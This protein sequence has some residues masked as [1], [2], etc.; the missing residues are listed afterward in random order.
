ME[1]G[2]RSTRWERARALG[3]VKFAQQ[4]GEWVTGWFGSHRELLEDKTHQIESALQADVAGTN[5]MA[6]FNDI[7]DAVEIVGWYQHQ[8]EVKLVRALSGLEDLDTEED[9]DTREFARHDSDGSAKVALIGIDRSLAAWARLREHFADERD[10]ILDTLVLLD[11][12]RR[13][14]EALLP[15]A[16]SF[17]RPGFDDVPKKP[18]KSLRDQKRRR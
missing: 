8:I 13:G 7:E 14:V 11:R 5:P 12:L 17:K 9:E 4:Y 10:Q 15:K 18:K 6:E 3:P 2:R 16:R 1:V